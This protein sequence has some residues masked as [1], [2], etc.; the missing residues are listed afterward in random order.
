MKLLSTSGVSLKLLRKAVK[1]K[2]LRVPDREQTLH[3]L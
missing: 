1:D 2:K 3:S